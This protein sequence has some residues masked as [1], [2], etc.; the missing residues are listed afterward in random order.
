MPLV[1]VTLPWHCAVVHKKTR[2]ESRGAWNIRD[3]MVLNKM[4]FRADHS[5]C[6][7]LM[8]LIPPSLHILQDCIW[9]FLV[10]PVLLLPLSLGS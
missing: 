7:V 10:Y 1:N 6:N 4:I 8:S 3:L 5:V 9:K 2:S